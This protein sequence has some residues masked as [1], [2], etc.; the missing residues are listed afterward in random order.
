MSQL[1]T[2]YTFADWQRGLAPPKGWDAADA[3]A[4]GWS[5][6][7]V[8]AWMRATMGEFDPEGHD[9]PPE[10]PV[11]QDET[12]GSVQTDPYAGRFD[13]MTQWDIGL[14][15]AFNSKGERDRKAITNVLL[16]LE[17]NPLVRDAF[18]YDAFTRQPMVLGPVPW[19]EDGPFPRQ[20][21]DADRVE[22]RRFLELR[23]DLSPSAESVKAALDTVLRRRQ[24]DTLADFVRSLDPWDGVPRVER[25]L[26][27]YLQVEDTPYSR[28][29]G[30]RWLIGAVARALRPGCKM[31]NML[32]LEGAQNLG[33]SFV[34][35]HLFY[36]SR[37]Y[38]THDGEL[39]TTEAKRTVAS[40]WCV[41][42][43]EL[44]SL[45]RS[46]FE[47]V[48]AFITT[49][50]DEWRKM[51]SEDREVVP[52]RVVMI[53]TVNPVGTGQWQPDQTGGRRFWP[54]R[55]RGKIDQAEV[56]ADRDQLWAEA[57]ALFE[58]G[59]QWWLTDE[60]EALAFA[61]QDQRRQRNPWLDLLAPWAEEQ[62]KFGKD[63]P[64]RDV[65]HAL[66]LDAKAMAGRRTTDDVNTVM[67]ELGWSP[68]RR[69]KDVKT[70][71]YKPPGA[72]AT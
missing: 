46:D 39:A 45:R 38:K 60:E 47:A 9:M 34:V 31:D 23:V 5:R 43:A 15:W 22:V 64:F 56:I 53:G 54:V 50:V 32:V 42:I 41:E 68:V 51:F 29:V 16:A 52:R 71:W 35:Q 21:V 10:D 8:I 59:E 24:I 17:H 13:P 69:G 18:G 40:A 44:A 27:H 66:Q 25:W 65:A 30:K 12:T 33:K 3:E 7:Q 49:Q 36:G 48:K 57:R 1:A 70:W 14:Q 20:L 63:V 4:D 28:A 19:D 62:A 2:S 11:A 58:A 72:S 26:A 55:V 37:F 6:D 61:Q 67:R